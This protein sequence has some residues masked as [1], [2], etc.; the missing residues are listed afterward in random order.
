MTTTFIAQ[1]DNIIKNKNL[2]VQEFLE[3]WKAYGAV[4]TPQEIVNLMI[5]IA[6]IKRWYNLDI[7]EPACGFCNFLFGIYIK[8]PYNNFTGIEINKE[9]FQKNKSLF[10]N[11]PFNLIREDFLLYKTDK[12]YDL[13]IGNPPYGIIGDQTHYPI[14]TLKQQKD[15]YKRI[16]NTWFGKYNIYGA[17][18]E[19]GVSLL[20]D[21]GVLIYIIPATWMVLDEFGRLRKFLSCL[22][23]TRVYYLGKDV[24]KGVSV[25]VCILAFEKDGKGAQLYLKENNTFI[26]SASFPNWRGEVLTFENKATIKLR[27]GKILLGEVFDIKISARSTEVKNFGKV[28]SRPQKDSLPFMNGRN[29]KRGIIERKNYTH[30]WLSPKETLNLKKFYGILPRIVIGHT[31]GGK[32]VAA[33]ENFGYPYVGDVYHLLPKVKL[34]KSVLKEIVDWLNSDEINKYVKTLYK[35]IT[36]H[37]TTTQLKALP[38]KL[39]TKI[40]TE[41][42]FR[43]C[44]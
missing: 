24:F 14:Y 31:K 4:S 3:K 17:F 12:K 36:P 32:I 40:N 25:S 34:N 38:L 9:I 30:L 44:H 10:S 1:A 18:I 15:K 26:K 33:Q 35:D 29:I 7:L 16:L 41:D 22:G 37:I 5:A 8:F 28:L 11:L 27:E 6:G 39:K 23:K 21:K 19:K 43:L 2:Q 20:K 42:L 13:I